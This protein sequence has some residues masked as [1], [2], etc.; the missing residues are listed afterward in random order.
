MGKI[1]RWNDERIA[2]HIPE[3]SLP[4]EEIVL[5]K[6]SDISDTTFV[7]TDYLTAVSSKFDEQIGKG[8]NVPFQEL[9]ENAK[10]RIFFC[11]LLKA[12]LTA[13]CF[14]SS[15]KRGL[16]KRDLLRAIFLIVFQPVLLIALGS[17]F[18]SFL[19]S[20]NLSH[21]ISL[22]LAGSIPRRFHCFSL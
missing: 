8:K 16:Q 20:K 11:V 18:S 3:L 15:D 12:F 14:C 17:S 5:A 1:T 22:I 7:F 4:D 6:R 9:N 10:I 19:I 2:Q 13:I 21:R